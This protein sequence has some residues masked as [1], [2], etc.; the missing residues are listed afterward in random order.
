MRFKIVRIAKDLSL[1]KYMSAEAAGMD[2]YAAVETPTELAFGQIVAVPTGI[3]ISIPPEYEAQIRPRS[4]LSLKGIVMPNAPG[5]IDA[6]YRGEV[7]VILI[8][9]SNEPFKIERGMR[10]AQMVINRIE[11]VKFEEVDE[12]DGTVRGES[13]FGSTGIGAR[14]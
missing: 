11:R 5:T 14:E 8:N 10:N 4:S 1:P 12:L 9:L 3:R 7:R 2:L 13:G 6:D